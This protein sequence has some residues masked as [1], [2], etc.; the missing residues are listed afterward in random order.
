M[1]FY[2]LAGILLSVLAFPHNA[3][4]QSWLQKAQDALNSDTGKQALGVLGNNNSSKTVS[5][6]NSSEISAG[7]REALSLGTKKVVGQLGTTDGFTLDP[8]IHIPLPG[9]LARVDSAL[10]TAGFGSLTEDLELRLNRAAEAATPKAKDLFISA[11]RDMTIEDAKGILTGPENAATEYLKKTMGSSLAK[12]ME[13][14]VQNALSSAGAIK[15]YDSVMGQYSEIPFMPDAKANL[16]AYVVE[17]AMDGIFYYVSQ[18]EAAIRNNPVA[19]TT[20]I[21]KRVFGN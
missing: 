1:R 21:L 16:K 10:S 14:I 13:P 20:D 15:A 2:F 11:I 3:Q 12:E 7:L 4:A 6:L 9:A 8:K 19:R 5:R 18:E 17:K